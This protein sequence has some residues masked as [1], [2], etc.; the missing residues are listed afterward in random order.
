MSMVNNKNYFDDKKKNSLKI[1]NFF[2]KNASKTIGFL[3]KINPVKN[4]RMK[5]N[6]E[7]NFGPI[8]FYTFRMSCTF[9]DEWFV[10][11]NFEIF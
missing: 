10:N 3:I 4:F 6:I 2:F 11:L 7:K 8:F 9:T 5:I 1:K